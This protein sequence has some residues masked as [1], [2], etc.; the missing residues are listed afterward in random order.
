MSLKQLLRPEKQVLLEK[1]PS[2]LQVAQ[3]DIEEVTFLIAVC[4][5]L[6]IGK[7]M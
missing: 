4:T 5:E 3:E 7:S 2:R 1:F 6:R